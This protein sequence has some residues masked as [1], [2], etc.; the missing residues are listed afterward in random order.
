MRMF[1]SRR[2][3]SSS[4]AHADSAPAASFD[5]NVAVEPAQPTVRV[6]ITSRTIW[7]TIGIV[8]VTALL[9]LLL[10]KALD[11]FILLFIAIILA[12]GLRPLVQAL[13]RLGV[14]RAPSILLIYLLGLGLLVG[15][16]FLIVG[17]VVSQ[18]TALA[19]SAPQYISQLQRLV[20]S[21][22]QAASANPGLSQ[23]LQAA[24]AQAGAALSGFIPALISVPLNIVSFLFDV[25]LVLTM[26]FLWL[27]SADPLKPFVVGL[28]PLR[29][30]ERITALLAE[31]SANIGGY[32]RGVIVNMLVIATLTSI[33]LSLLGVP[34]AL[35]LGILAGLFEI[36]PFVGPWISGGVAALVALATGG[37][38]R[39]VEVLIVFEIIQI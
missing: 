33:A 24:T 14:P 39:V 25:L 19:N 15:L 6:S 26:A 1:F 17:P 32:T 3:F 23:V 36:L 12:E 31:L 7:I 10:T 37:P 22:Q 35:L 13:G 16:V 30:Q 28:F 9:A 18:S 34:Y 4:T 27:T 38:L 20:T 21:A 8:I 5:G 11:A 2:P 29:Y